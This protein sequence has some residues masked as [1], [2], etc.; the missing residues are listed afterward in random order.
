MP[1]ISFLWHRHLNCES[2]STFKWSCTFSIVALNI[3]RWIN[4]NKDLWYVIYTV[5]YCC[6]TKMVVINYVVRT[7]LINVNH[8][9]S[10]LITK[11]SDEHTCI[12]VSIL[13]TSLLPF[14]IVYPLNPLFFLSSERSSFCTHQLLLLSTQT[15]STSPRSVISPVSVFSGNLPCLTQ[16]TGARIAY[17][18][19]QIAG[20]C[21]HHAFFFLLCDQC[22]HER[23]TLIFHRCKPPPAPPHSLPT[24]FR[25]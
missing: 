8:F 18:S 5:M 1:L 3:L 17:L 20:R 23:W 12:G 6:L 16:R 7:P 14:K 13:L 9:W 21:F 15:Q 25:F 10:H 11:R 22:L 4:V 2:N 19:W 24:S